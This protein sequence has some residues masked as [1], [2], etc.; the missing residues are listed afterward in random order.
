MFTENLGRFTASGITGL[1]KAAT[2]QGGASVDG[3]FDAEYVDTLGMAGTNPVFV[4]QA[5]VVVAADIGKTL[6]VDGT[7]YTIRNRQP[8]EDG[9]FVRLQLTS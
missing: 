7:T 4:C 6:V 5:T 2:L 3:F 9:I 1:A 8:I